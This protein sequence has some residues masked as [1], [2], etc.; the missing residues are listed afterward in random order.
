MNE[1][2]K[3]EDA[4]TEEKESTAKDNNTACSSTYE[5]NMTLLFVKHSYQEQNFNMEHFV[6]R[7]VII[8]NF[9]FP[10]LY[11]QDD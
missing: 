4:Y 3:E 8:K 6:C 1:L 9:T 11:T 5:H 2:Y 7:N 10:G